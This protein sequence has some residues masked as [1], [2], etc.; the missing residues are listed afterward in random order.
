MRFEG[1]R[2][3]SKGILDATMFH[4]PSLSCEHSSAE[5]GSKCTDDKSLGVG[6]DV[7]EE[8]V[9]E[10]PE[11]AVLLPI[12]PGA[13]TFVMSVGQDSEVC[14]CLRSQCSVQDVIG[15]GKVNILKF[16]GCGRSEAR[17]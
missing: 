16:S 10:S 11:A 1:L 7:G 8:R 17:T 13:L 14:V 6:G 12:F 3:A 15:V 4:L 2:Y 5:V 9:L